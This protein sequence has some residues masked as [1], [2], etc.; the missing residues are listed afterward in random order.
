MPL[1]NTDRR[2]GAIAMTLH[3]VMAAIIVGLVA[4]GLYMARLPDV[5]F[6]KTKITL[7]IYHKAFG[8]LVLALVVVR[9]AWRVGSILPRLVEGLPE[10]QMVAARFVHLCFYALMLALPI[11]GWLMSSAAGFPV[12][13]FGWFNLPDLIA[14]SERR[15]QFFLA[16]HQWLGYTLIPF[17]AVHVAAA[18]GHHFVYR[19]ATLRRMLPSRAA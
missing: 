8:I 6:D 12:S 15:F 11:T 14:Y 9:L 10:W 1:E 2:Y 4:V 7:I 19:D 16:L 13:F 17:I 5:G 18:V 3:W